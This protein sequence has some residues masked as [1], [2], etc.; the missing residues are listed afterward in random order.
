LHYLLK[1]SA[2]AAGKDHIAQEKITE[3][4]AKTDHGQERRLLAAQA[5][6][7]PTVQDGAVK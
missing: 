1:P 5:G 6:G 3:D 7:D 2:M 4:N